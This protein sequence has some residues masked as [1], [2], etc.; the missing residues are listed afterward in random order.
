MPHLTRRTAFSWWPAA[1]VAALLCWLP[2]VP[3][4]GAQTAA[5]PLQRMQGNAADLAITP[6][7][8]V[9]VI[10]AD[11]RPW[12]QRLGRGANWSPLQGNFRAIR[13]GLDGSVWA[14]ARDDVAFR[15]SA[16]SWRETPF[17]RLRDLAAMPALAAD[18]PVVLLNADGAVEVRQSNGAPLYRIDDDTFRSAAFER[19]V[20]DEHGL[21]W[22]WRANGVMWRFDGTRWS[23]I[24]QFAA[25]GLTSVSAGSDGTLM[26]VAGDGRAYRW[27]SAA[28]AWVQESLAAPV[29]LVAIGPRGKPWYAMQDHTLLA[30]EVFANQ[31]DQPR[32][33][34]AALF[35]RLLSWRRVRGEA[36]WLTVGADG[37]VV[38]IDTENTAWRWK[39]GNNW[40]PIPGKFRRVAVAGNGVL[41]GIDMQNRVRRNATGQWIDAGIDA[42]EVA[43]G[44]K[45]EVWLLGPSGEI[46]R[47]DQQTRQ[48]QAVSG[49]PA[50]AI[51]VGKDG[52]G[53]I[54]DASGTVQ[55]VNPPTPIPGIAAVSLAIGPEGT[56]YA[57][58]AERQLFWL[59]PRERQWKPATGIAAAVAVGPA[60][61]PWIIGERNDLQVST[62][63]T[64]EIDA[65]VAARTTQAAAPPPVFSIP[66]PAA[67]T[68]P[69]SN[70]PLLYTTIAGAFADVGIGPEGNVFAAGSDGGLYCF[71][72]PDNRFM[73]ASAGS[74]RRVAVASGGIPWV[75]NSLGQVSFFGGTGWTMVPGF[76]ADDI[77]VGQDGRVY[78][79]Q[80]NVV[81]RYEAATQDFREVTTYTSG[82]PLRARRVAYAQNALWGVNT[83]NQL[84]KCEGTQ[85]QLQSVGAI[86][87]S[88]GPDGSVLLLDAN[89]AVQ[90][91]NPRTRGFD[92][93]NGTGISLSVGPQ[94]RPWL[95]TGAG[96]IN[97]SGQF[98]V[99]SKSINQ[100]ACAQ[101]FAGATI[102]AVAQT[103]AQLTAVDDILT[104]RQGATVSLIAN[105]RLNGVAPASSS[106]TVT[107]TPSSSQLAHS[108]GAVTVNSNATVGSTLT[109]RY[110][111][112]ALP[113]AAPCSS[114]RVQITV[115]AA[116]T[117]AIASADT[118]TI[119]PGA[120]FNLLAN[121]LL[122]GGVPTSGQVAMTFTSASAS[123]TQV[124]GLLTLNSA[125]ARGSV[126]TATYSFCAAAGSPCSGT[127]NV[128]ITAQK[129]MVAVNDTGAISI[130]LSQQVDLA[131]NDTLNGTPAGTVLG[132]VTYSLTPANANFTIN[133]GS[134]LTVQNFALASGTYVVPYTVCE[135]AVATNCATANATVNV[136][137]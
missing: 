124:G 106:V 33:K 44:P 62:A 66:P 74:A 30:S 97:S 8:T 129:T 88:S 42:T 131:T 80:Q 34:P 103:T 70:R 43:V 75:V 120:T 26:A 48:W 94:G 15:L 27:N 96:T 83:S 93:A 50:R 104:V 38:T 45:E 95:V 22:V 128:S 78:A 10:D 9:Y 5:T 98:A 111:V 130:K 122:N 132:S 115:S 49:A 23:D 18:G 102:P 37:T 110:T 41:W 59:D 134:L 116:A 89:G 67:S 19:I 101:R 85:C 52:E 126:H 57:T 100:A 46:G 68:L 91:Y 12:V 40:T 21:P 16:G 117:T 54:I 99:A 127:V 63:F 29:R 36:S 35:T 114:A 121:D 55:L 109:G 133:A 32:A 20:V 113:A 125:A 13:A 1:L 73:L 53:W 90:R 47:F 24:P 4:V 86:D 51:A 87:V 84:L 81:H 108:N 61:T 64:A 28:R 17:G 2:G 3:S 135:N 72:N 65:L 118:A 11:G 25:S 79:T 71:S 7:G 77:A 92:P 56:V 39:G 119:N 105:D 76:R 137:P 107:F 82:V 60:G 31:G 136:T 112:C 58:T 6:D 14:I 69:T 123:L